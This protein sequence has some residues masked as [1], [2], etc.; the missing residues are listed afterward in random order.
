MKFTP[1]FVEQ[2]THSLE[3]DIYSSRYLGQQKVQSI[4]NMSPPYP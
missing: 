1:E 4:V 2:G 3:K